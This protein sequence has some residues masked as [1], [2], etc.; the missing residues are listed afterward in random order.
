LYLRLTAAVHQRTPGD[1]MWSQRARTAANWYLAS[2]MI[3]SA[4]LV[5]DGLTADCRNNGATVWTYNQGLGIGG[6]VEAW[7]A[8][9]DT[10]LLDAARRLADAANAGLNRNGVLRHRPELL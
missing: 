4:G 7:R 9:D 3:N 8:T 6:L 2:G 10:R 5:N 1:T